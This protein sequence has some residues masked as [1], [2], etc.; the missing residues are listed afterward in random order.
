MRADKQTY[1][2][3]AIQKRYELIGKSP[4]K[5]F[6]LEE[7]D[8]VNTFYQNLPKNIEKDLQISQ[9]YKD[10]TLSLESTL[11]EMEI[12]DDTAKELK[13]IEDEEKANIQKQKEAL[14]EELP[15]NMNNKNRL[16]V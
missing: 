12:V 5:S 14:N 4:L 10:G 15:T 13:R 16:K 3:D 7:G 2:D 11:D 1:F 9:L 8:I 6:E